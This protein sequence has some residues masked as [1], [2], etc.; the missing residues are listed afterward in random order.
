MSQVTMRETRSAFF[1]RSGIP[2][3][4]GYAK[5]WVQIK[6]G[7]FPYR[8]RNSTGRK[9]L[10]PAHD[11]HH[12]LTGYSTDFLGESEIAAWEIGSGLR[13]AAGLWLSLRVL[14]F[15]V[16]LA[17]RRIF[18]AYVRGRHSGNLLGSIEWFRTC[19][20]SSAFRRSNHPPARST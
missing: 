19:A 18:R 10:A 20:G 16:S 8:Y 11:L 4:G 15:M 9:R 6:I 7:P 17:P 3:D 13:D 12:I 2:A 1:E 5:E 14:G